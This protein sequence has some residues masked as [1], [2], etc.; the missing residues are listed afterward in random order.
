MKRLLYCLLVAVTTTA[1]G[2]T[3][4]LPERDSQVTNAAVTADEPSTP[5]DGQNKFGVEVQLRTRGEINHGAIYPESP[6]QGTAHFAGERARVSFDY[7]RD[8]LQLRLS[9]QHTGVW[10]QDA[11]QSRQGR[12]ALNEAWARLDMGRGFYAQVGRQ[13]LSFDD[14]RLLGADDWNMAGNWHDALRVGFNLGKMQTQAVVTLNQ[15]TENVRGHYYP[16]G[17]MP[18]KALAMLWWHQDFDVQPIGISLLAMNLSFEAGSGGKANTRHM[19]TLGT[20]VTYRP[21]GWEAAASFYLQTGENRATKKV[22]AFMFSLAG[23]YDVTEEWHVRAGYDYLSGNDGRNTNQHAFDPLFGSHHRFFGAMDYFTGVVDCGLQDI[24][25]GCTT[26]VARPVTLGLDYHALLCAE[27]I[28]SRSKLM[29]HE[30]DLQASMQ[31]MRDVKISAGY[32]R[33][34][35]TRTMDAYMGGDHRER[36]DWLWVQLS[37]SPRLFSTKW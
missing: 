22:S 27:K 26:E 13:Q 11:M 7:T 28:G 36:Q 17:A 37:V 15:V 25:V 23:S 2:Q 16:S 34:F 19:Q 14:E 35:N 29:G 20:H 12:V 31:L 18:Y 33:M 6:G 3:V 21:E 9:A 30:L 8:R 5:A 24:H 32:S 1:H 4:L 10:G